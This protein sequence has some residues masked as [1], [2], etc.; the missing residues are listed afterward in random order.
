MLVLLSFPKVLFTPIYL[1]GCSHFNLRADMS[2]RTAGC[3]ES[4]LLNRN[5]AGGSGEHLPTSP[6]H[7]CSNAEITKAMVVLF[8]V[9]LLPSKNDHPIRKYNSYKI[10]Q[11]KYF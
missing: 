9:G 1:F 6:I 5:S 8:R 10:I 4:L 3:T 2:N 7:K 11:G